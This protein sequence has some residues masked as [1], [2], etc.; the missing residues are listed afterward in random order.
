MNSKAMISVDRRVRSDHFNVANEIRRMLIDF[1]K[2]INPIAL[3][4]SWVFP[5]MDKINT[6]VIA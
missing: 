5:T 3:H 4:R 1:I 6:K 2:P